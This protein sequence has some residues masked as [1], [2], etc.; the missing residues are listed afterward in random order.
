MAEYN[1]KSIQ[2]LEGLDNEFIPEEGWYVAEHARSKGMQCVIIH[3]QGLRH[4]VSIAGNPS[5]F[6]LNEFRFHARLHLDKI[7]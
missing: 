4:M 3:K 5:S 6:E 1:A 7:E 2:V